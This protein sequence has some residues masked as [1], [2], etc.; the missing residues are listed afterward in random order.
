MLIATAQLVAFAAGVCIPSQA[1]A[2]D[3]VAVD[4]SP[5]PD[6]IVPF[7]T[8]HPWSP[9][10]GGGLATLVGNY[11]RG[12]DLD[13][14]TSGYLIHTAQLFG[15]PTGLYRFNQGVT[16]LITQLPITSA[17]DCGFTLTADASTIFYSVA[18][19]RTNDLLVRG[20]VT[21][22]FVTVG[23]IIRTD[24]VITEIIGLAMSDQG[25]LF[26]LDTTDDS[27]LTINPDTGA[28]TKVGAFGIPVGGE[29]ELDFDP[30]TGA[31]YMAAGYITS[32]IYAVNTTTG[33]ATWSGDLPF[34][35]SAIAFAGPMTNCPMD[36]DNGTGLGT[37]DGAVN[38]D[39]LLFFL[40][41]F[42]SGSPAVD[43]DNGTST[44]TPNGAVDIDDLLF[45]LVNF[46]N[47]C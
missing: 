30:S 17:S 12:I 34:V 35:T 16:T 15:T 10:P 2:S 20:S 33:A 19:E 18:Q 11:T 26:A 3:F 31:L 39:D 45:F 25:I 6:L 42:E 41:R 4:L 32:R 14:P 44:G 37:P 47:G 5:D 21:G 9:G 13:S 23:Q 24:A 46:E 1:P 40:T 28:A 27:L 7:D 29:G 22:N 36:L 38:I 43:L 8:L